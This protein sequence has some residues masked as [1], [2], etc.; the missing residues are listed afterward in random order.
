MVVEYL[1]KAISKYKNLKKQ[2]KSKYICKND[3]NKI[4]FQHETDLH[5]KYLTKRS[6]TD[7]ILRDKVFNVIKSP[8]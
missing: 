6:V 4:C 7:K 2:K 8:K 5:C 3:L 1:R